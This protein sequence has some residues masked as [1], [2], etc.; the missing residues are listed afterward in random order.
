MRRARIKKDIKGLFEV[1]AV[2]VTVHGCVL[3]RGHVLLAEEIGHDLELLLAA[4]CVI[5]V[6][7][8]DAEILFV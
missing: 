7:E 3:R 6:G 4:G 5:P 8:P 1:R 2:R